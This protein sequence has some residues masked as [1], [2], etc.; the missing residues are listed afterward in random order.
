MENIF[1]QRFAASSGTVVGDVRIPLKNP[2]YGPFVQRANDTAPDAIFAFV[3]SGEGASFIKRFANRGLA[4]AGGR[5]L[6]TGDVT[7]DDILPSM[8]DAAIGTVT[9]HYY[10]AA[11]PSPENKA[12][13]EA[14][15]KANGGLRPN[16]M[17]VGDWD[18][19][20]LVYEVLKKADGDSFVVAARG[21]SCTSPRGP[22]TIDVDTRDI[23]H[24]TYI[25]GCR[26]ARR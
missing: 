8:G 12:Y 20:H 14:F 7:N 22:V 15:R 4:K 6:A 17:S 13:V 25:R 26:T 21:M 2:D 24:D 1:G 18:G 5:L 19:M 11:H 9:A 3:P 16:F 10:S 23:V